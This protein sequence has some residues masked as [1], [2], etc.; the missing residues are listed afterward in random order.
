METECVTVQGNQAVYGGT[1]THVRSLTGNA[2]SIGVGWRFYF[3]VTDSERFDQIANT[4]IFASPMSPSLCNVYLPNNPMW[5][6]Q[7]NTNVIAPGFVV[8]NH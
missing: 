3:K 8:V 5:S 7:G 1:I 4:T 6:S 2:P